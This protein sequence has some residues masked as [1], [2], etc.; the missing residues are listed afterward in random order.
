[1]LAN[2]GGLPNGRG[3]NGVPEK[4]PPSSRFATKGTVAPVS[5]IAE[6]P[7]RPNQSAKLPPRSGRSGSH[8][9]YCMRLS[10]LLIMAVVTVAGMII[11]V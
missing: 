10:D 3:H 7:R 9:E 2:T 4:V 6:D 5:K 1:V 11:D 8:S